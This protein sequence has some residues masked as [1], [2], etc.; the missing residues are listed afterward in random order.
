MKKRTILLYLLLI[1]ITEVNFHCEKKEPVTR[2][3]DNPPQPPPPPPPPPQPPPTPS[4]NTAPIANAGD[5]ML[6][7]SPSNFC[8]LYGGVYDREN[9]IRTI[10]WNEISGPSSI[11]IEHPDSLRTRISNL[12]IGVYKFELSVTDTAGLV[13]KDT[14]IVIVG[15]FPV[16]PQ[17]KIFS[18]LTWLCPWDCVVGI[19]NLYNHIPANHVFKVFI[20]RDNSNAWLELF[21]WSSPLVND[22]SYS[23]YN[24][25]LW[26]YYSGVEV[27]DTPDVKIVY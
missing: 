10:L 16:N 22:Y 1:A 26:I 18:N 3:F 5:D 12:E 8:I 15:E 25:S 21:H 19:E 20:K 14:S 23:F 4:G 13:N 6:V 7:F 9:N 24:G 2:P 17:E 27:N 11:V